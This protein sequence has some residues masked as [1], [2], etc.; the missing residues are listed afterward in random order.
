MALKGRPPAQ[1]KRVKPG[2]IA[3]EEPSQRHSP[4]ENV[5]TLKKCRIARV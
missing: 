1:D 3:P 2:G 4:F 5:R